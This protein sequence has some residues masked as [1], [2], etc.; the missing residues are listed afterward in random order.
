[1]AE[2]PAG[3]RGPA[4]G[5]VGVAAGGHQRRCAEYLSLGAGVGGRARQCL[6]KQTLADDGR[7]DVPL[8][9]IRSGGARHGRR[10]LGVVPQPL[11]QSTRYERRPG[12]PA[13]GARWLLEQQ[14]RERALRLPQQ[15]PPR[16]PQQQ[17]RFSGGV[18]LPHRAGLGKPGPSGPGRK[19]PSI[20]V[21]GPRQRRC[22]WRRPVPSA[23]IAL[24][25]AR[26][27]AYS[28]QGRLPGRGP[29][30]PR[31]NPPSA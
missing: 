14:S 22:G 31:P 18:C 28:E 30:A 3:P 13:R 23:R 16:Q 17:P 10:G 20:T 5:R 19:C 1:V 2:H 29:E 7:G 11:R 9:R 4:A 24:P 15:Q 8:R 25:G 12:R 26:R 21:G 27:R 6:G